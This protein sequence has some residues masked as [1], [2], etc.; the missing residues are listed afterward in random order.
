MLGLLNEWDGAAGAIARHI[1]CPNGELHIVQIAGI[2]FG[3][4][5]TCAECGL[6]GTYRGL[7]DCQ[8]PHQITAIE[9]ARGLAGRLMGFLHTNPQSAVDRLAHVGLQPLRRTCATLYKRQEELTARLREMAETYHELHCQR[10]S[11]TASFMDCYC[12]VCDDNRRLLQRP[13]I[14]PTPEEMSA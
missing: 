2:D 5:I 1:R 11:H 13:M 6:L 4:Q 14:L 12:G 7:L 9:H 3:V 10:R 8:P